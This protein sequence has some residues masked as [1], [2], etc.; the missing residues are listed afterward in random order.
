MKN[1]R[2]AYI[3]GLNYYSYGYNR[4]AEIIGVKII[5]T[6]DDR[7]C[8][9]VRYDNGDEDFVPIESMGK[10]Y[11]YTLKH[12]ERIGNEESDSEEPY[13]VGPGGF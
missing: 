10:E 13:M 11:I 12:G 5:T 7:P 1:I 6:V 4:T 3:T 9:H 2:T 8:F